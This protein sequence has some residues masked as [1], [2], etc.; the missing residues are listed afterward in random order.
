M[1]WGSSQLLLLLFQEQSVLVAGAEEGIWGHDCA[2]ATLMGAIR[3]LRTRL[4]GSFLFQLENLF[5]PHRCMCIVIQVSNLSVSICLV[6][7][8]PLFSGVNCS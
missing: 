2:S 1:N 8:I 7:Y 6:I 3:N 5:D 4:R